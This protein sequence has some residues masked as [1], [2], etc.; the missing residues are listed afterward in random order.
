MNPKDI[1]DAKVSEAVR[2]RNPHLFGV[3]PVRP[4]VGQQKAQRP[5]DGQS[6][7]QQTR[8]TGVAT[9]RPHVRVSLIHFGSR[10]LD[11]DN[12][13]SGFK[14]YRDAIA[15]SLGIDDGI[16]KWDY[17]QHLTEGQPGTAVKIDITTALPSP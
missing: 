9:N 10:T 16:I 4:Q 3:V 15:R 14:H 2:R 7:G 8:P 6:Q 17:S 13:V 1:R 5:L 11:D 12:L